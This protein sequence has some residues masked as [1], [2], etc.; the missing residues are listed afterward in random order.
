MPGYDVRVVD[1]AVQRVAGQHDRLDRRQA[2]AAARRVPDAVAAGRALQGKLSRGISRLLQDRR[3]RLSR[4]TTAMST[5]WAAP[6]TSSMSPAIGFRPAAWRRCWPSH[7]DVA[8]CAVIGI[9][10]ALKGEVPCGFVV[11]K[12][13]VNQPPSRSSRKSSRWCATRSARW[14]RSSWRSRWRGC[15]RRARARFCAAPCKKIADGEQWTM[16]ATID[17]PA[18]FDEIGGALKG[19][20]VGT[21]VTL[22]R[23]HPDAEAASG[24]AVWRVHA[25]SFSRPHSLRQIDDLV[26]PRSCRSTPARR[27]GPS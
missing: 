27:D 16:P 8:E 20:G 3:R 9:K 13:G 11:L 22:L 7:P 15:R 19:K 6:T 25:R 5:S 14:R 2:A 4:T 21:V 18:I 1:E 10:D 23:R 26:T 24:M 17:D 12:S